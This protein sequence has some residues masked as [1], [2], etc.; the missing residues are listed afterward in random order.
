MLLWTINRNHIFWDVATGTG[1]LALLANK[2]MGSNVVG[3]DISV[4]MLDVADKK[5][6]ERGVEEYVTV[7]KGDSE[8]LPFDD[9]YI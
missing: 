3:V 6:K 4:G 8:N 9:T 5:I 1:D 2:R 7:V